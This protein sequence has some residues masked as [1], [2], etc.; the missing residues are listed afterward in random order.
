MP[1]VGFVNLIP[2]P[3]SQSTV[4][5]PPGY[6]NA[7]NPTASA[8]SGSVLPGCRPPRRARPSAGSECRT[9]RRP[10]ASKSCFSLRVRCPAVLQ[11]ERRIRQRPGPGGEAQVV[12]FG[13]RDGPFGILRTITSST[14]T[15]YVRLCKSVSPIMNTRQPPA[16]SA[17]STEKGD[18]ANR[19][20][21]TPQSGTKITLL[22]SHAGQQA[23]AP[24]RTTHAG[25]PPASAGTAKKGS[26]KPRRVYRPDNDAKK[27]DGTLRI[28]TRRTWAVA[29]GAARGCYDSYVLSFL[30]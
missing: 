1:R 28:C 30:S 23:Q 27:A 10:T 12:L 20:A 5:R 9:M 14:T 2:D 17:G 8:S 26:F 16:A 11:R 19:A 15:V 24:G 25:K 18:C 13:G 3:R 22:S 21:D 29:S 7:A 6:R 4:L